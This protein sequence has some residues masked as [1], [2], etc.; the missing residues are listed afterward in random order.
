MDLI[1][2]YEMFHLNTIDYKIGS[3]QQLRELILKSI[4]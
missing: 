3:S 1:D 2:I 4:I